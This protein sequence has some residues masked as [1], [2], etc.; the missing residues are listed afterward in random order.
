MEPTALADPIP[1][2]PLRE[3]RVS[4]DALRLGWEPVSDAERYSVE[5][6]RDTRFE[7][8]VAAVDAGRASEVTLV[9][10]VEPDGTTYFWR[11]LAHAGGQTSRGERVESFIATDALGPAAPAPVATDPATQATGPAPA[12]EYVDQKEDLGPVAELFGS[13]ATSAANEATARPDDAWADE[14][15]TEGVEPEG[16]ASAQI[17]GISIA[18]LVAL[19][20]ISIVVYNWKG[21]VADKAVLA[22]SGPQVAPN[23][24]RYPTLAAAEANAANA[25]TGY[26]VLDA[27]TGRYRIPIQQAMQMMANDYAA[28]ADS[29]SGTSLAAALGAASMPAVVGTA[30]VPAQAPAQP[31]VAAPAITTPTALPAVAPAQN[32]M[33]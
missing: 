6:A 28:R 22:A 21:L 5:I 3:Q 33:R 24:A 30:T 26:E 1:I 10:V 12:A 17:L 4:P 15:T 29:A 13:A 31:A 20:V 18:V 11:V 32:P 8:V 27:S 16:I 23:V 2:H 7:D 9:D 19:F 14:L 25:L